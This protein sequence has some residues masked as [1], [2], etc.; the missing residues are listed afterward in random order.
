MA[1]SPSGRLL[2]SGGDDRTVRVWR[3]L[4]EQLLHSW[5]GHTRNVYAVGFD[6]DDETL[7]SAG[8][9]GQIRIWNVSAGVMRTTPSVH[10]RSV[11]CMAFHHG[12]VATADGAW[13]T[14]SKIMVRRVRR[15]LRN[16]YDASLFSI[17]GSCTLDRQEASCLAFSPDGNILAIGTPWALFLWT[18]Q[19]PSQTVQPRR[20]GPARAGAWPPVEARATGEIALAADGAWFRSVAF[21][22]DGRYLAAAADAGLRVWESARDSS[23]MVLGGLSFFDHRATVNAISFSP[24]GRLLASAGDDGVVRLWSIGAGMERA[25]FGWDIGPLYSLAFSPDGAALAASGDG[26]IVVW[27]VDEYD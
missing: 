13:R 24:L 19:W 23:G 7:L 2:A 25:R 9:D 15:T 27:D 21:S 5:Q 22:A 14:A 17:G 26:R 1:W 10:S 12:K 8:G 4:P 3:L 6:R 20:I 18:H 11:N 16:L